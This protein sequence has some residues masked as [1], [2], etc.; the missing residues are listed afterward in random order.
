MLHSLQSKAD[1]FRKTRDETW[2]V[3]FSKSGFTAAVIEEAQKDSH[4]ILV[5]LAHIVNVN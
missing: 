2:Y 4:I 3:L 1:I 5:D